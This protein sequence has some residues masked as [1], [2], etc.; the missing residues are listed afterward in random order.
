MI[1]YEAALEI[2]RGAAV[3]AAPH[4]VPAADALGSTAAEI[5]LSQADV[6]AFANAALDGYAL[7]SAEGAAAAV[8]LRVAGRVAA[9][10]PPPHTTPPGSAW[11][12]MTGAPMPLDCDAVVAHEA[13]R[14][15]TDPARVEF[16]GPVTPGA[17]RRLPGEDVRVGDTLLKPGQPIDPAA[18]MGLA[19][20]ACPTV[21]VHRPPRV[22]VIITGDELAD[23]A[24]AINDANGPFLAAC[25]RSAGVSL[26]AF[27]QRNDDPTALAACLKHAAADA[28]LILTT[29]GVSAGARDFV[30]AALTAAG[31]T[32]LFHKVAIRPGKPLAC[33]RF[34]QG[35][36]V[37]G[38][39]GN[40]VAV[41]VGWRFFVVPFLRAWLGQ[42]PEAWLPARVDTAV[43][44]RPGLT[45]FAKA[46]ARVDASAVLRVEVLP[47]QESFKIRPLMDANCWAVVP[48]DAA[49]V[50]ADDTV[51]V[52]PLSPTGFPLA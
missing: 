20:A 43:R 28:D 45:F 32:M 39:P 11:E 44:R 5:V 35:P 38:L 24:S 36:V 46:R 33:A 1:S 13:V 19:A 21:L 15:H 2:I 17:N 37:F 42:P 10:A 14:L 34:P 16:A 40:P 6:P 27:A 18:L 51:S 9:G 30:P 31:A 8:T 48:A 26:V 22:S 3:S 47:G 49:S 7:R 25:L 4:R 50:Q 41:A 29:G 23:G 12:I 52:A